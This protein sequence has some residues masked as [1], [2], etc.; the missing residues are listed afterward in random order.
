[1]GYPGE[2]GGFM[3][4]AINGYVAQTSGGVVYGFIDRAVWGGVQ[5][6]AILGF[7]RSG[8]L[9]GELKNHAEWEKVEYLDW[10][11]GVSKGLYGWID[12]DGYL[13]GRDG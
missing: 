3:L 9:T 5:N 13:K 6:C 10:I 2:H 8:S 4:K 1:M 7:E 12:F 11:K